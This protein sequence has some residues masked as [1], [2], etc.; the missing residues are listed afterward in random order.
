MKTSIL[1]SIVA[2]CLAL[3]SLANVI[4]SSTKSPSCGA[5]FRRQN[6][7]MCLFAHISQSPLNLSSPSAG[8]YV[9]EL[10]QSDWKSPFKRSLCEI[11]QPPSHSQDL[12]QA[13]MDISCP[14][15]LQE[16]LR[17]AAWPMLLAATTHS[18]TLPLSLISITS[19][20]Q[21]PHSQ[22]L[23]QTSSP[24][25]GRIQGNFYPFDWREWLWVKWPCGKW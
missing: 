10:Q 13:T 17:Y 2:I 23:S 24:S 1:T 7:S 15:S 19:N 3:R 11:P 8:V 21:R 6:M 5:I 4:P 18:T 25:W 12:P 16:L 9:F 20:P 14:R 22:V